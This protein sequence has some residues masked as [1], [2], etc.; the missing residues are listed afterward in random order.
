MMIRDLEAQVSRP[1]QEV[2]PAEARILGSE[3][4]GVK[5][6][7]VEV[8]D[9]ELLTSGEWSVE[10]VLRYYDRPGVRAAQLMKGRAGK[11]YGWY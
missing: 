6:L 7:K 4:E 1:L 10:D 2:R 8:A 5:N 9:F 3:P 11:L